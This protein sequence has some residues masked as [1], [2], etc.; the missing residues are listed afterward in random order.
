MSSTYDCCILGA[1]IAGTTS[2]LVLAQMGL[3]VLVVEAGQHPRFAIGESLV[4]TTT[5]GFD[6][7]A[8]TYKIPELRQISHYPAMMELELAGWPKLGFWF[9]HHRDGQTLQT[10]HEMMFI[11][12]G[13][14]TGPD[15]HMLREGTD[16][17]L[18]S[19]LANY[20]VEYRDRT[21]VADW[22][23]AP[24]QITLVLE[25]EGQQRS[26]PTRF[27]LDCSGHKSFLAGC[28][29]LRQSPTRLRTDTRTIFSHFREVRFLEEVVGQPCARFGTRRDAC[30]IHH[31]FDGGWFWIIRFDNGICSVG[32]VLDRRSH[33]DNDLKAEDEFWSF[34]NRFPT[35]EAHLARA[36]ATRPLVKS[37]RLQ[38]TSHRIFGDRYLLAPQAASFVDPL[39]ST[40]MDLTTA[41]IA[42]MSPIV[43]FV[44][45]NDDFSTERFGALDAC[46][47]AEIDGIDRIVHGMICSFRNPDV[48]KQY[49]RCWINASLVQ[50]LI[51]LSSDPADGSGLLAHYGTSLPTWNCQL[52]KM[53]Q[54][55]SADKF[56][57]S[58]ELARHLKTT[59]DAFPELCDKDRSNWEIGSPEACCPFIRPEES[60]AWFEKLVSAEPIL[61]ARTRPDLL[62]KTQQ[63]FRIAE[64][65]FAQRYGASVAEGTA[66]HRG[67]NFIRAQ[68]F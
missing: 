68:Q 33:P 66:F 39:F 9:G 58:D 29:N 21:S 55:V 52:E 6:Y 8:R 36:T 13:L 42:R 38:F 25:R 65:E 63:R 54:A 43:A 28:K 3:R 2:A 41:F 30:T 60:I 11:T 64:D 40:G 12:P 7:L 15:V 46:H 27:V 20:G 53:Y 67:V 17:F 26:V 32:L 10:G 45:K 61:A 23:T 16:S 18:T 34:V 56:T 19:R 49:W 35:V 48:L 22:H 62:A 47:Q 50:Y 24:G 51:Q 57:S 14:P 1:G 44:A 5:L 4:P 59:M 37:G 31:C